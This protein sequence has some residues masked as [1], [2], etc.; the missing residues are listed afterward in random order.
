MK[1]FMEEF[2]AF[3]L[4]GNV[5]DMAVGV[6]VGGAFNAI[7][8]SLVKDI[9]NP[10]IGLFFNTDLSN[11]NW[12]VIEAVMDAEGNVVT[13]GVAIGFGSFA[14]AIINFLITAFSLF[15]VI[16]VANKAASLRKKE[17]E[18]PAAPAE[19]T[20]KECPYCLSKI[21]IKATRCPHCTS[22]LTE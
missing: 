21:A 8:N 19:P 7:V 15:V 14:S 11:L 3:A 2:K 17:E 1:K 18:A 4:R 10:A 5:L 13:A 16:K 9:I 22:Q 6:V 12:Q 20:E